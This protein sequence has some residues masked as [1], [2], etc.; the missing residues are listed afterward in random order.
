MLSTFS[1]LFSG[2]TVVGVPGNAYRDGYF[3][4]CARLQPTTRA[5]RSEGLP[6][7]PPMPSGTPHGIAYRRHEGSRLRPGGCA[8]R[9]WIPGTIGMY[10][11]F[12]CVAPRLYPLSVAHNYITPGSY[13]Y[14][15]YKHLP[16]LPKR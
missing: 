5:P 6:P 13:F 3:A 10:G 14:H 11:A 8:R 16:P 7:T 2:Y 12:L 1:S 4:M 15:R 9:Y